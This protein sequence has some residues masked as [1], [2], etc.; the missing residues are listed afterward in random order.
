MPT[1]VYF[2]F[3]H[4]MFVFLFFLF[5]FLKKNFTTEGCTVGGLFFKQLNIVNKNVIFGLELVTIHLHNTIE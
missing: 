4:T 3:Q 1:S 5:F 2:L